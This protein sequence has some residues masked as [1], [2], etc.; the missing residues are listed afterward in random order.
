MKTKTFTLSFLFLLMLP[1]ALPAQTWEYVSTMKNEYMR[2]VCTKGLDTVFVVGENGLIA[3]SPDRALTWQKQYPVATRLND[4]VFSDSST[5]F[6][7][8]DGGVILKT[9]DAGDS[10]TPLA[11]GTTKNINAL[12]VTDGG[13]VWAVGD[14][15]TILCSLNKGDEWL[16]KNIAS[17]TRDLYDVE[18]RDTLGYITGEGGKILKTMDKG[19]SWQEYS[20]FETVPQ[21]TG[22]YSLSMTEHY[23]FA[24]QNIADGPQFGAIIYTRNDNT[25]NVLKDKWIDHYKNAIYFI[26]NDRGWACSWS[27][28]GSGVSVLFL[29]QTADGGESWSAPETY[30]FSIGTAFVRGDFSFSEDNFVGY[31]VNG[32][33]LLRTPYTGEFV[34]VGIENQVA[35]KTVLNQTG[36]ILRVSNSLKEISSF[37]IASVSGSIYAKASGSS[38]ECTWLKFLLQMIRQRHKNGSKNRDVKLITIY[39][40]N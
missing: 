30:Q 16:A 8:G 38:V 6:A 10:W 27:M 11:S 35:S 20:P 29:Y 15:G 9:A 2:K 21:W 14:N 7:V 1:A 31:C 17:D 28:S 23:T 36:N 22:I 12:A 3:C 24:L 25:W 26:D 5:G 37:R 34:P 39:Y 40:E 33:I 18:F 4:I 19:I 32:Q 13:D